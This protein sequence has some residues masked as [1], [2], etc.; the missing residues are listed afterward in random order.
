MKNAIVYLDDVLE[1]IDHI[2]TYIKGL[3][4]E[5]FARSDVLQDA[6]IRR[7]EIIG[8]AVKR[9]PPSLR[10]DHPHIPW[11]KIAGMRDILIHEYAGVSV[12]TVWRTIRTDLLP[13]QRAVRTMKK[14][15]QI[16]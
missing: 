8:E 13:L 6:V 7:L 12:Q 16:R 9:L 2:R 15:A 11:K 14:T 5:D 10:R 3:D 4:V 1:S